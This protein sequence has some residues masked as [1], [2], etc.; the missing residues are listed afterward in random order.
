MSTFKKLKKQD[1]TIIPY[2]ANKQWVIN[3][4][5]FQSLKIK[6]YKVTKN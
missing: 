1:F 3:S 2:E 6:R 4:A 5:D